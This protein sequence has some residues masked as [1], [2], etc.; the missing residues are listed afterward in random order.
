M[1][2]EEKEKLG[3]IG[4]FEGS[5]T[6]FK[7][8]LQ[9]KFDLLGLSV[10]CLEATVEMHERTLLEVCDE[11]EKSLDREKRVKD[12]TPAEL[13]LFRIRC[14]IRSDYAMKHQHDGIWNSK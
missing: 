14:T 10:A 13:A 2:P 12:M 9:A 3:D 11:V 1:T 6:E 5:E 4:G 8:Q 7:Q